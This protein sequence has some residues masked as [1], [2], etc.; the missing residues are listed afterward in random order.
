VL[1]ATAEELLLWLYGRVTLDT[2][3]IPAD[4]LTAVRA[5]T[6]TD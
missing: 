5:L 1:A 6:N 2:S 3:A 4:L